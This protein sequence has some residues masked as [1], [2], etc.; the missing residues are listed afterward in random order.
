MFES[1]PSPVIMSDIGSREPHIFQWSEY[2]RSD[3][4]ALKFGDEVRTPE[5]QLALRLFG[6]ARRGIFGHGVGS[7]LTGDTIVACPKSPFESC[8]ITVVPSSTVSR[9]V[10]QSSS[11]ETDSR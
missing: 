2:C 4:H 3:V 10:N 8:A 11:L 1:P 9:V 5:T 6:L 7:G